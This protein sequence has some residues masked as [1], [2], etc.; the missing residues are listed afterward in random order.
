M[1]REIYGALIGAITLICIVLPLYLFVVAVSVLS[2]LMARELSEALELK[3][4]EAPAFLSPLVFWIDPALGGIYTALVS[5]LYGSKEW[6]LEAY[7]RSFFTLFY[8]GFFPSYLSSLK[9]TGTYEVLVLVLTIWAHDI[10]AYYL[11]KRFGKKVLFERL[12]PKKTLEGYIF[13]FSAGIIL[14][15]ILTDLGFLKGILTALAVLS[16]G[17]LGDYFKSFIKR[18]KGIKD[19][20]NALGGHGGFIDRFDAVIFSAPV[21]FWILVRT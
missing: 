18:Q 17:A 20:S 13:G 7:M 21:Y 16:A 4:L 19:F 1:N 6:S 10:S 15:L 12:S 2:L 11:G 3:G 9:E 5:L 14:F 8:V